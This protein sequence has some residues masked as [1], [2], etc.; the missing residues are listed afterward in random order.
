MALPQKVIIGSRGS[1]LALWQANRVKQLLEETGIKS[2]IKIISTRGDRVQDL[3]FDKIEGK[4]FFTKEI[5]EELLEGK[6]DLAVHS[7]KDLPTVSPEGLCIAAVSAREDA[8]DVL[9]IREERIDEKKLFCLPA[10][11]VVGT[12]SF[13]R[14]LLLKAW[15]IDI[16]VRDLRGNVPTRVNKL[17]EGNY[18][19]ILLAWAGIKRLNLNLDG[20]RVIKLAHREFP[21]AP[22][23][24]VLAMQTRENDVA[25]IEA[26]QGLNHSSV[27]SC[28]SLERK[29]LNLL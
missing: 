6:I 17:R 4:G 5:E 22:A 1:D 25:L 14:K 8:S 16:D 15:R 18:D 9:L 2:E 13:R 10:D 24:G 19:A 3:S 20:L 29:V 21:P 26:L 12:S 28:I 23:Q 7:H 27:K 11:A